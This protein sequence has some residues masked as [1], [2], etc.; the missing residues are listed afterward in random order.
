MIIYC[1]ELVGPEGDVN[2][3]LEDVSL[4]EESVVRGCLL[5]GDFFIL[6]PALLYDLIGLQQI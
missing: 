3:L 2:E 4:V 5:F 6:T 1:L